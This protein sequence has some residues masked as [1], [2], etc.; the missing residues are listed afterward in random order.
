MIG[1]SGLAYSRGFGQGPLGETYVIADD[2]ISE[3][4][5]QSRARIL[6]QMGEND[7]VL[8][9]VLFAI[10]TLLR[11]AEWQVKAADATPAAKKMAEDVSDMFFKRME[12]AW[13]DIIGEACTCFHYGYAPLEFVY[14]QRPDSR[15]EIR[16]FK[17]R[18]A[19]KIIQW[20]MDEEETPVG[21]TIQTDYGQAIDVPLNRCVNVRTEANLDNPEGYSLLR[22]TWRTWRRK[23]QI[24]N[25]EGRAALRAAGFP[26]VTVPGTL[27][28]PQTPADKA[29]R[30]SFDT[31][32]GNL[33]K[34]QQGGI[35]LPSDVDPNTKAPLYTVSFVMADGRR[36]GDMT[37]VINRFNQQMASSMLADFMLLG[38]E[39]TKPSFALSADKTDMFSRTIRWALNMIG[40]SFTR[41][42]LVP[43]WELNGYD[44]ALMPTIEARDVN[45]T[46]IL[47]FANYL[48]T[49]VGSG[50]I[51]PDEKLDEHAREVGQ[52][53][54]ADPGS[55]RQ[56][57]APTGPGMGNAGNTDGSQTSPAKPKAAP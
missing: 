35:L 41:Q 45:D 37:P 6:R 16:T 29:K 33:A 48:K 5:G 21:F 43:M 27:F 53:P 46:N 8:A 24:E 52:L 40:Q 56:P 12:R 20:F 14:R 30:A 34:D 18:S 50:I 11:S 51:L 42:A 2:P 28:D 15:Y 26:V 25:A 32:L 17:L 31:L 36:S 22:P 44:P 9:G 1:R 47:N 13:T 4:R 57:P 23:E 38:G 54:A 49:L 7:L 19:L 39:G 10:K 55:V 3:L